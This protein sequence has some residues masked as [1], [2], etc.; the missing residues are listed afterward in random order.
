M[1]KSFFITASFLV[2]LGFAFTLPQFAFNSSIVSAQSVSP[3]P[4]KNSSVISDLLNYLF[5]GGS[6][7]DVEWPDESTLSPDEIEALNKVKEALGTI[8]PENPNDPNSASSSASGTPRNGDPEGVYTGQLP[9]NNS[10]S[11]GFNTP[12]SSELV[13][14]QYAKLKTEP[15]RTFAKDCLYYEKV[16]AKRGEKVNHYLICAWIWFEGAM[17]PYAINCKDNSDRQLRQGV[18]EVCAAAK[19]RTGDKNAMMQIG[20][21][22]AFDQAV[23]NN[24]NKYFDKCYPNASDQK[25]R[26]VLTNVYANSNNSGAYFSYIAQE[27]RGSVK[28]FHNGISSVTRD[29]IGKN[30]AEIDG[31]AST[32]NLGAT[33]EY[34]RQFYTFLLGKDP[35][36]RVGLNISA[37]ASLP[38][39]IKTKG[40]ASYVRKDLNRFLSM[41]EALRLLDKDTQQEIKNNTLVESGPVA[42]NSADAFSG[43][44]GNRKLTQFCQCD[45]KWQVKDQNICSSGCGLNT[46]STIFTNLGSPTDPLEARKQFEGINWFAS[47]GMSTMHAALSSQW[48]KNKGMYVASGNLVE[49]GRLNLEKAEPYLRSREYSGRC[50]IAGSQNS[51]YSHIFTIVDVDVKSGKMDVRD[52]WRDPICNPRQ[53]LAINRIQNPSY[54]NYYAFAVCKR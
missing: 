27:N 6:G 29:V 1:N 8:S 47:V 15:L 14:A 10:V 23:A 9:S 48:A 41:M 45:P 50:L 31:I 4:V 39:D 13:Q 42:T 34:R 28:N 16:L 33:E 44:F 49:K 18:A 43:E 26:D 11:Y 20:G 24:Y 22:Q 2:I 40:W 38:E 12:P 25:L 3:T 19:N 17:D 32:G 36:M 21:Y 46:M 53:G 37:T 51:P 30:K 54:A 5:G 7:N 52:S 35:C